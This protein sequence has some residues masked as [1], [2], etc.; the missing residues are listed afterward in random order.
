MGVYTVEDESYV[1]VLAQIQAAYEGDL[2]S[3]F[4]FYTEEED[5]DGQ[6]VVI[7]VGTDA[8]EVIS[9]PDRS[10]QA[11]RLKKG[12]A[13]FEALKNKE[14]HYQRGDEELINGI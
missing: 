2:R 13:L 12:D 1:E 14:L 4:A 8:D 11:I 10:F 6:V 5:E 7:A 3:N 9:S